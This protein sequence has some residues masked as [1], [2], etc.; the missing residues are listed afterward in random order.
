MKTR[1]IIILV[2]LVSTLTGCK[3]QQMSVC[4]NVNDPMQL[5]WLKEQVNNG[6][7]GAQVI[8][9]EVVTYRSEKTNTKGTGFVVTCEPKCCDL[10]W[11]GVYDCEGN[12]L[13]SY[14]GF[15]GGCHGDC[16]IVILSRKTIYKNEELL[17]KYRRDEI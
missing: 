1:M 9:V 10:I 17:N 7:Q 4:E 2:A 16:S 12:P 14:G 13:N 6:Y 15:A 5:P 11:P 3:T 8:M